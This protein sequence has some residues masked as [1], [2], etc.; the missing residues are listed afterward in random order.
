VLDIFYRDVVSG[1]RDLTDTSRA[2]RATLGVRGTTAGWD[3]DASL[4]YSQTQLAEYDNGGYPAYSKLLPILNS[5]QVNFFG[6]TTDPAVLSAIRDANYN[7]SAYKTKTTIAEAEA[8]ASRELV[9]LPAG[10]LSMAVDASFRKEKFQ[11]DPS[12]AIQS[13]DIA[14]YGGNFFPIDVQRNVV[15]ASLELQVP[16]VGTLQASPAV[17]YDHY[18]GTGGKTTPKIG[19]RWKPIDEVLLRASY[20]KG[21]RAPSLTELFSP[22]TQGTSSNGLTD[23]A[24][25][26]IT[27]SS[28][29]CSAQFN[30]MLG[31]NTRLAPETSDTF[32]VGFVVEPVHNVSLGLDAFSIKLKNTIIFGIDP[33]AILNDPNRYGNLIT[34]GPP[35]A[36]CPGCPGQITSIDQIN[37]NFGETDVKGFDVDFR[38]RIPAGGFGNITLSMLGSYF[39]TYRVEQ[40]D[41]T[42]LNLAG[43]VSPITNGAGGA[44]PRWHHFASAVWDLGPWEVAVSQNYQSSYRDLPSTISGDVRTVESYST[45]DLQGSWSGFEGLKLAVGARNLLN[46]DPPYSNVGG[47]NFFQ[48]GYDPG[49]ADP[50]GLFIYGQVTYTMSFKK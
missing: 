11:T 44:I 28:L 46:R 50:H 34:R 8:S 48:A 17:R 21:F 36:N 15:G 32:T 33:F 23:N 20:S 3:F 19:L 41:G 35:T 49:Y 37:T 1:P 12:L 38:A 5:G 29:D 18:Q 31:G 7:G 16:I 43:L 14:G 47:Q 9:S 6:P 4:L 13:G 2:P 39:A 25:C 30:I 45:V 40:A 26:P 42:F 24:R 22:V 10:P 27:N